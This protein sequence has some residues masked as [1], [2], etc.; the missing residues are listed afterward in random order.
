V[1][2]ITATGCDET[3]EEEEP[4]PNEEEM[5][6]EH[7]EDEEDEEDPQDM[8]GHHTSQAQLQDALEQDERASYWESLL[9]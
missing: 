1:D 6:V 3:N 5:I 4:L 2:S 7:E 9:E 8:E